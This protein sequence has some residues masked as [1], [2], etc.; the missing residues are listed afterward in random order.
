MVDDL[1]FYYRSTHRICY[2]NI[3]NFAE[4]YSDEGSC[5]KNSGNKE[6]KLA[7]SAIVVRTKKIISSKKA[8]IRIQAL[9]FTPEFAFGHCNGKF[10]IVIP[11]LVCSHASTGKY[12]KLIFLVRTAAPIGS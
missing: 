2:M 10:K 11:V 8:I 9:P 1:C 7:L 12:E 4:N 3:L 5:R 6:T